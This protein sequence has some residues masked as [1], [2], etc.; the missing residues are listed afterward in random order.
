MASCMYFSVYKTLPLCLLVHY[1]S[2]T[3]HSVL[4]KLRK[5]TFILSSPT[6]TESQSS[7][8]WSTD[9]SVVQSVCPTFCN[10]MDCCTPGF[11]V[12]HHHPEVAQ[13]HVHWV[14]GL[15]QPSRPLLSPYPPAFNLSQHQGF[16]QRV[17]SLHQ[18]AKVL[19]LQ[20]QHHP[21]P[22]RSEE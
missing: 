11:R 10:P 20:L 12:L 9:F 15:I 5:L 8:Y 22:F 21:L 6:L 14:S 16:F 2:S 17:S 19:G 18:V 3:Y 7:I 13:T 1:F 4:E